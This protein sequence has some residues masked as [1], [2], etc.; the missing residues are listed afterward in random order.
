[1]RKLVNLLIYAELLIF[2]NGVQT[3]PNFI[4]FGLSGDL[5]QWFKL[6]RPRAKPA[7]I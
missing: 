3:S 6:S 4:F 7:D 2:K 5:M 1:M